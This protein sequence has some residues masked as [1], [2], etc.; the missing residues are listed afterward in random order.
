MIAVFGLGNPGSDYILTRH[1]VGFDVIDLYRRRH[2]IKS[3]GRID[4]SALVYSWDDILLVK[5]MTYMNRSGQAVRGLLAKRGLTPQEALVVYDDLDLPLGRLKV[6]AAGGAGTH[7][8]MRS[9]IDALGTE[10]IP[11]L[12][13]GIEIE[14]RRKDGREFVLE[15]FSPA[16]WEEMLPALTQA[17]EAID[18]FRASGIEAVMTR[19]NRKS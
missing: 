14:D 8:G 17:T 7:N 19:Y 5:P 6:L 1:N 4:Q 18:L 9:V 3:K 16:E 13:I 2:R 11:R 12:R 10:A 15:R